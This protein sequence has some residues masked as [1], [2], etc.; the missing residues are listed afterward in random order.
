MNRRIRPFLWSFLAL[1]A[2]VA[3]GAAEDRVTFESLRERARELAALPHVERGGV[4]DWIRK[5]TYDQFRLIEF[6]AANTLWRREG[7][8]SQLQFFHPGFVHDRVVSV[9]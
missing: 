4:P 5:L 9:H 1:V 3:A 7:L 2:A 8:P 6:D